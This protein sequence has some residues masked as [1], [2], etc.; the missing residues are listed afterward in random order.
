MDGPLY[1]FMYN[2]FQFV[3]KGSKRFQ[4]FPKVKQKQILWQTQFQA[5]DEGVKSRNES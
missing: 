2:L 1:I 4:K 5:S 3:S